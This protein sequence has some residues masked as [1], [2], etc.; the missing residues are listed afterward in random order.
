MSSSRQIT[1]A[2]DH[3]GVRVG[4]R[5]APP[6]RGR[7]LVGDRRHAHGLAGLEPG[8]GLDPAAVD[9]DFALAAHALDAALRDA[10][11]RWRRSQRSSRWSA[12][13]VADGDLLD[14]A[15]AACPIALKGSDGGS[16]VKPPAPGRQTERRSSARGRT[17]RAVSPGAGSA[18][19]PRRRWAR[20]R[21]G[22]EIEAADGPVGVAPG[23]PER[24][25]GR[26][27]D[28][29]VPP[30][31]EDARRERRTIG[32]AALD[33]LG[34]TASPA[35]EARRSGP[36]ADGCSSMTGGPDGRATAGVTGPAASRLE[37]E[38]DQ[39]PLTSLPCIHFSPGDHSLLGS[40][41]KNDIGSQCTC[42]AY[43]M[44]AS[45]YRSLT[46]RARGS[47]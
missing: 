14:A 27:P 22:A 24:P 30:V 39:I 2:A 43:R 29:A 7:C 8:R 9:A 31:G 42:V 12:S 46:Q 23:A 1:H 15:H 11:D 3:R 18:G 17:A 19:W 21:L 34:E 33:H 47:G 32:A 6:A 10:A 44:R 45:H 28:R 41:T 25:E 5:P 20:L 26:D 16:L 36:S 40:A 37:G 13:S 38:L 4:D 35:G